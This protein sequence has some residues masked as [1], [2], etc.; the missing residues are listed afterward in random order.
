[1][2]IVLPLLL[3]STP[4]PGADS[5]KHGAGALLKHL[6]RGETQAATGMFDGRMRKAMPAPKLEAVWKQL[7][8]QAG[9]LQKV[10]GSR[11][12]RTGVHRTVIV[13]C[14]FARA[15]LDM[16]VVFDAQGAISGLFFAP[17]TQAVS[18][19]PPHYGPKAGVR[20]VELEF[21]EAPWRLPGTLTLPKRKAPTKYPAVVL[22]HGS[23]PNDRDESI[24][25]NK[26]F[27]DLAYGLA[28]AGIASFRYDKRTLVHARKLS[29]SLT[30]HEETVQ[31]AVLAATMLRKHAE[32]DPSNVI[33]LGHSL[34]ATLVPRIAKLDGHSAGFIAMAPLAR[35]LEDAI[36]D[37]LEY[38]AKHAPG[39]V[40]PDH[41]RDAKRGRARV[42][43]LSK[44]DRKDSTPILGAAAPYWLDLAA[45]RPL[46][47][48]RAMRKPLLILQ[49]DRDYQV[50]LQDFKQWKRALGGRAKL[51]RYARLNHLFMAGHGPSTPSEY[52]APSHVDEDVLK[53]IIQWIRELP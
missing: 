23:G 10:L 42:R 7:Q 25:P 12:E 21:G 37:Q 2:N 52:Q 53:D 22:V 19:S 36:V 41:I 43:A 27:K 11:L 35:P 46:E 33:I 3:L 49:G 15:E 38:I 14:A 4:N 17:H 34:G 28:S 26:P 18:W 24:G 16:K 40:S 45:Y 30:V 5:L 48:A 13:H 20:S 44:K 51:K 47:A 32:I 50:T 39:T 1:M 6:E 9:P 31:D 8:S 29:P